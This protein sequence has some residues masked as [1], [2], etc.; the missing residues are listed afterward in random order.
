MKAP[1]LLNRIYLLM[2]PLAD[3]LDAEENDKNTAGWLVIFFVSTLIILFDTTVL[4]SGN[5]SISRLPSTSFIWLLTLV[6][7]TCIVLSAR[8]LKVLVRLIFR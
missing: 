7:G 6:S 8:W 1:S 2:H 3:N 5:G 4:L